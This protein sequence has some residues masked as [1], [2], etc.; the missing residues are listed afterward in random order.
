MSSMFYNC[1]SLETIY[2]KGDWS[3]E[4]VSLNE[5]NTMFGR[6]NNLAGGNGTIYDY[7]HTDVTYA[8]PDEDGNPGYFTVENTEMAKE[9]LKEWIDI[10]TAMVK[11]MDGDAAAKKIMT[12]AI[13]EATAIYENEN[14]LLA[15]VTATTDATKDAVA[16]SV[17][18]FVSLFKGWYSNKLF[19]KVYEYD[20]AMDDNINEKY[21]LRHNAEQEVNKLQWDTEKSY[22]NNIEALETAAEAIVKD[23]DDDL[24]VLKEK[25]NKEK[26]YQDKK[27]ALQNVISQ[28]NL[29][30]NFLANDATNLK[31]ATDAIAAANEV[32]NNTAATEDE[33]V[34]ATNA[35]NDVYAVVAPVAFSVI[36]EQYKPEALQIFEQL[37]QPDDSE[38]CI[39]I[40]D[41]AK[42]EVEDWNEYDPNKSL[43]DNFQNYS[44]QLQNLY[45]ET[46]IKLNAQRA[47]DTTT[48]IE[49]VTNDQRPMTN[50][51]IKDNQ[52]FI[53]RDGK[54]YNVMGV[55]VR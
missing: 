1:S 52:I 41:D 8:H 38:A 25:D 17:T 50:K 47:K 16:N 11:Y 34:A 53:L 19:E 43:N 27:Q 44:T 2:C 37:K 9:E 39:K 13:A 14:A 32:Y 36:L 40:V 10:A 20:F 49:S 5:S 21:T 55:E 4:A 46:V 12:D 15:E 26:Q 24:K 18:D 7:G 31:K 6:C 28:L 51:I 54:M 42:K 23:L 45:N 22:K 33:L 35:A 48:G 3:K 29:C 30:T